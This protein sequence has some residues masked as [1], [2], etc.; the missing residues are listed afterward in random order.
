[1]WYTRSQWRRLCYLMRSGMHKNTHT[2]SHTRQ[3]HLSISAERGNGT[4]FSTHSHSQRLTTTHN[5][6]QDRSHLTVGRCMFGLVFLFI[7]LTIRFEFL[8]SVR[9]SN[10]NLFLLHSLLW[11]GVFMGLMVHI[12]ALK[13]D[14]THTHTRSIHVIHVMIA[15]K[16]FAKT[17]KIE[18]NAIESNEQSEKNGNFFIC[19]LVW[20]MKK[21][22]TIAITFN[23]WMTEYE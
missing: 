15:C 11:L 2:H 18:R 13:I 10:L 16:F 7:I 5:T 6:N 9:N 4:A 20:N 17:N 12:C 3:S 8:F 14:S 23:W 1:M 19:F 22:Q 21:S